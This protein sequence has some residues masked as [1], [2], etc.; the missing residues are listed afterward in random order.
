[1]ITKNTTINCSGEIVVDNPWFK[2]QPWIFKD[3]R[4]HGI[5]DVEK[6]IAEMCWDD[7]SFDYF[8]SNQIYF[9]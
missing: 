3:F 5:T 2:D 7:F 8:R 4:T 9:P 1:M 6:A